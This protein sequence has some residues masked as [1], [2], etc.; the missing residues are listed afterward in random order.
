MDE[1]KKLML[2]FVSIILVAMSISF[3]SIAYSSESVVKYL[4]DPPIN[5]PKAPTATG[6]YGPD[7]CSM[8]SSSAASL[9]VIGYSQGGMHIDQVCRAIRLSK[10]MASLGL[11]VGAVSLLCINNKDVIIALFHAGSPCPVQMRGEV[12]VGEKASAYWAKKDFVA[13]HYAKFDDKPK[14]RSRPDR[15]SAGESELSRWGL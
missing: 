6:S 12:L 5:P 9:A 3:C 8:G 2:I 11:K 15:Q 7:L 10:Q 13:N 1:I 14:Y 4:N